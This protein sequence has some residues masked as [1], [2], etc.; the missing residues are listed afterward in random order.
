M[1]W[2][3]WSW[4]F[5]TLFWLRH[6]LSLTRRIVWR[7]ISAPWGCLH[8]SLSCCCEASS[9]APGLVSSHCLA[10][11]VLLLTSSLRLILRS[12]QCEGGVDG[13]FG[14]AGQGVTMIASGQLELRLEKKSLRR[15]EAACIMGRIKGKH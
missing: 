3:T 1:L 12:T 13:L 7:F 5:K 2:R 14:L 6:F 11:V 10:G 8:S 15:P 4:D 9:W